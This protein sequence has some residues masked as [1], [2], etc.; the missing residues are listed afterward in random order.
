MKRD[1]EKTAW[2]RDYKM[3]EKKVRHLT[4][5]I[6]SYFPY[7]K[8]TTLKNEVLRMNEEAQNS[9]IDIMYD[10]DLKN[11]HIMGL[12]EE[13]R[14]F[15]KDLMAE[16]RDEEYFLRAESN[17]EAIEKKINGVK[18]QGMQ[19]YADIEEAA[20]ELVQDL[21]RLEDNLH[22]YEERVHVGDDE[23]A[24]LTE[25]P[26]PHHEGLGLQAEAAEEAAKIEVIDELFRQR[27]QIGHD[28][29]EV[30]DKM[31]E[32][33]TEIADL[34]KAIEVNGGL[35][36]GWTSSKDHAEYCKARL[37]HQG[38]TESTPFFTECQIV[39]PLYSPEALRS[40][41]Q[42][43]NTFLK[44][45]AKRKE[46]LAEYK[47]AKD[48][49]RKLEAMHRAE[50]LAIQEKEK[51]EDPEKLK[52][53]QQRKKELIERWK[54]EKVTRQVI[55][56]DKI[57]EEAKRKNAHTD[58]KKKRE[59]EEKK[60]LV[61][62][63]REK[64]EIE[65]TKELQRIQLQE[66]QARHVSVDQRFRIQEKEQELIEKKRQSVMEKKL[67]EEQKKLKKEHELMEK[68]KKLEKVKSK[69]LEE[70]QALRDKARAKFDPKTGQ[71]RF[72]DNMAGAMIRTTGKA[73]VTW[74]PK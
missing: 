57:E 67:E 44:L 24:G 37:R 38:R 59:L 19:E 43:Y 21:K 6:I 9:N 2:A 45:E 49:K 26:N 58:E 1:S 47:T 32:I 4:V 16:L 73:L 28:Y 54:Q 69:L 56:E 70:T 64:K 30:I 74:M 46:V 14:A 31:R 10:E 60:K 22:V 41:T 50:L 12:R 55:D 63:Y 25:K 13:V 17:A 7:C 42:A 61:Q 66:A 39:L 68:H 3:F 29:R 71:K 8:T 33:K 72:A 48:K 40:H 62:E 51:R 11:K 27:S 36:C 15:R 53:E 65:K 5:D 20:Q 52:I 18:L 35:N 23:L 34:N